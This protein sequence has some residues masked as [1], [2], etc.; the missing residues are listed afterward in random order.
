MRTY[1][2]EQLAHDRDRDA[3]ISQVYPRPLGIAPVESMIRY[4]F[5]HDYENSLS[6]V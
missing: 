5:A 1:P 2:Q 3:S 4:R 6:V